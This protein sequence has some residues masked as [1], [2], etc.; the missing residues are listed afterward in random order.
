[1]WIILRNGTA[2]NSDHIIEI[3]TIG[4]EYSIC[5]KLDNGKVIEVDHH[6]KTERDNEYTLLIQQLNKGK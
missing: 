5:Y 1:M 2:V 3:T 4:L 6:T